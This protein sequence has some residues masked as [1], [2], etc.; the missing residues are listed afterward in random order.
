MITCEWTHMCHDMY[1]YVRIASGVGACFLPCLRQGISFVV[2]CC[3]CQAG[4]VSPQAS[5]HSPVSASQLA[6]GALG[7]WM[8]G[9]TP[10]YFNVHSRHSKS[11]FHSV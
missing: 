9:T 1:A 6:V 10:C 2:P 5:G 11:A 4:L 3:G 8:H 7:L